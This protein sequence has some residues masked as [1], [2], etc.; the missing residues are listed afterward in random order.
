MAEYRWTC[1]TENA[2]FAARDGAGALVFKDRMW[3]L[4]GWNPRDKVNFPRICNSEVWSSTDG[5]TWTLETKQAPWEGRHTAGYAVHDGKMWIVGGDANQKH[6]QNDVW[7][8]SD[9]VHWDLVLDP[10][11]WAPRVLH[12]T[13]AFKG[14][15]WVMGG[16]NMTAGIAPGDTEIFY[17]DVWS[18][19][20]GKTWKREIEHAAWDPRGM[21]GGAAVFKDRIWILGGGTY[22]TP[23]TKTRKFYNDVWSSADGVNWER[24]TES[25]AWVARQY[26]D[27]GVFDD[28]MWVMEGYEGVGN[29]RD[30]WY[31]ADGAQWHEVPDT[32]WKPR[33]AASV[34][35]YD[36]GLWMVAGNNMTPDA[37]KLTRVK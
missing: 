3:L 29:R 17:N 4:G 28:K 10:V 35:V 1:V 16:P 7:S 32:P 37:W 23:R 30:V 22:D 20:D 13:V 25:A 26:H 14:K 6:Y 18:S 27:V 2:A 34:F 12:Y 8:S 5:V 19:P 15:I 36:G 24:H 31:S 33:H 11:P 21:I 9:G